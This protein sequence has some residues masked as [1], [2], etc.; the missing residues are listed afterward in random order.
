M[1]KILVLT[2]GF[3][4]PVI[5]GDRLRIVKI[6]EELSKDFELDLLCLCT[7]KEELNENQPYLLFKTVNKVY[8]PKYQSL[9]QAFLALFTKAPIHHKYYFSSV[10]LRTLRE[11]KD[12]YDMILAHL[13]RTGQYLQCVEHPF[14]FFELTD[15]FSISYKNF[16]SENKLVSLSLKKLAYKIETTREREF[17]KAIIPNVNICSFISK[18]TLKF[19]PTDLRNLPNIKFYPNGVD[20]K[21][22]PFVGS[23]QS[24][25]IIFIGNMGAAQNILACRYFLDEIFPEILREMPKLKFK[26]IGSM[27]PLGFRIFSK[28]KNVEITGR[29][30]EIFPHV[31][32][33]FCAVC[34][35]FFGNTMQNKILEYMA[36]GI[37]VVTNYSGILGINVQA[38]SEI[39]IADTPLD[40]RYHIAE[41][42]NNKHLRDE[43]SKNAREYVEK[44]CSWEQ[45][46]KNL[47]KD[48]RLLL[49]RESL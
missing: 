13:P 1:K 2:V 12:D 17:E 49:Q 37:P 38:G 27:P 24:G 45:A 14:K 9:L 34:P 46:L 3:P 44:Y 21:K 7:R 30:Q 16:S 29:V 31:K 41:L 15:V 32:N 18:E 25:T 28:Y 11:K 48:V 22:F 26:I 33:S 10:F 39:L 20:L 23:K 40:W 8:L 35:T 47:N 6:C 19:L 4:F 5:K 43:L 36:L 42:Y